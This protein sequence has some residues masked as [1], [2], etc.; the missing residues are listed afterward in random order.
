MSSTDLQ[1]K[2]TELER[3]LAGASAGD[4]RQA[5]AH[6]Q[7]LLARTERPLAT[8]RAPVRRIVAEDRA[9]DLFDNMPV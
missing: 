2:L 3:Q 6:L 7:R 5:A 8:P 9:V 1:R 4:R